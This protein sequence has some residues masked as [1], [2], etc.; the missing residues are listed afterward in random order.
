[1]LN[2]DGNGS[3]TQILGSVNEINNCKKIV[4]FN[5][6]GLGTEIDL[7]GMSEFYETVVRQG[8]HLEL[9]R[10]DTS[11]P[12]NYILKNGKLDNGFN[13]IIYLK[14]TDSTPIG[15]TDYNDIQGTD[16]N[17]SI[18]IEVNE[19]INEESE[20]LKEVND[21][22]QLKSSNLSILLCGSVEPYEYTTAANVLNNL[23]EAKTSY[24]PHV[25]DLRENKAILTNSNGVFEDKFYHCSFIR[26]CNFDPHEIGFTNFA[27]CKVK[28]D[29][30]ILEWVDNKYSLYSTS[31]AN[32][33]GNPK[34][35]KYTRDQ[36]S[37]NNRG[38]VVMTPGGTVHKNA[39]GFCKV[40]FSKV[41]GKDK[42]IVSCAGRY[43]LTDVDGIS[44]I[45]DVVEDRFVNPAV[46]DGGQVVLNERSYKTGIILLEAGLTNYCLGCPELINLY[47]D[48][49]TLNNNFS[50]Y[51]YVSPWFI[52]KNGDFY[53]CAGP[54]STIYLVKEDLDKLIILNDNT[55]ILK[56]DNYYTIYSG[57]ARTFYSER[58]RCKKEGGELS[59]LELSNGKNILFN[60]NGEH[61]NLYKGYYEDKDIEIV[62]KNEEL[63]NTIF[64][65]YRRNS[66]PLD[67]E[68]IP[69]IIGGCEGILFYKNGKIINYL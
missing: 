69:D 2:S 35:Y 65:R 25:S 15:Y 23:P 19:S 16:R 54:S 24:S 62:W 63:Y 32:K 8:N 38:T 13:L 42:K 39:S 9:S 68:G 21:L 37:V 1:M 60:F 53:I 18:S 46:S 48:L 57:Y 5:Q 20:N 50:I 29:I 27:F 43:I 51:R 55:I 52:L 41:E 66:Y 44:K 28:S 14:N 61:S 45:Y 10:K 49:N 33:F 56:E 3:N 17:L 59:S 36:L 26:N 64:N 22:G 30:A 47:L 40:D 6:S 58:A 11:E 67:I 12:F 34:L 31:W 7:P 4:L